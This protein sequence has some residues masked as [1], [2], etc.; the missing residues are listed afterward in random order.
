MSEL[1]NTTPVPLAPEVR[2]D[3]AATPQADSK[4]H[5]HPEIHWIWQVTLLSTVMGA[6]L[7]LAYNTTVQVRRTGIGPKMGVASTILSAYQDNNARLQTD[8]KELREKIQNYEATKSSDTA[9]VAALKAQLDE[10]KQT[11]G[12]APVT[13]PGVLVRLKDSPLTPLKGLTPEDLQAYIVHDVDINGVVSELKAA[14][15]EAIAISGAD[16]KKIQRVIAVTT[17]RCVGPNVF[18]NNVHIS[19]PYTVYAI[20]NADDLKSALELPNGFVDG[21]SL[22][23]LKMIEIEKAEKIDIP[24]YEGGD[25]PKYARPEGS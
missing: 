15:A 21:R 16:P 8:I 23:Y 11:A 20:G 14:G 12:F 17:A 19:A 7:A 25:P 18:V 6:M 4:P 24:G 9:R 22:T 13:G 3:S 1:G 2:V 10:L 5:A